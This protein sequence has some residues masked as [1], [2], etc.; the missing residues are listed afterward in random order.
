MNHDT[1]GTKP[2]ICFILSLPTAYPSSLPPCTTTRKQTQH[3]LS[4]MPWPLGG[5]RRNSA[6]P[7]GRSYGSLPRY[8]GSSWSSYDF[9]SNRASYGSIDTDYDYP[10]NRAS[11]GSRDTRSSWNSFGSGRATYGG[12]IYPRSNGSFYAGGSAWL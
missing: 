8:S 1:H 12:S 11:Y 9:P 10:S 7:S 3:T 4:N 2:S 6:Y 5:R